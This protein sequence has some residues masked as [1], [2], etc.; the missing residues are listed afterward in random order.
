MNRK[1]FVTLMQRQRLMDKSEGRVSQRATHFPTTLQ[2]SAQ[3]W[4]KYG[5]GV[6]ILVKHQARC[7]GLAWPWFSRSPRGPRF[8]LLWLQR[9]IF[10]WAHSPR[11][12]FPAR[13]C[14]YTHTH[15]HTNSP[16]L[17]NWFHVFRPAEGRIWATEKAAD[18]HSDVCE[19]QNGGVYRH[20]HWWLWPHGVVWHQRLLS[21]S[22]RV[23]VWGCRRAVM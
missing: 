5:L 21:S 2:P 13:D 16:L 7:Q 10:T 19:E 15:T 12:L 17:D 18:D 3:T 14:A 20:S 9:H 11:C 23:C 6:Q 22:A 1:L 4:C 8:Q